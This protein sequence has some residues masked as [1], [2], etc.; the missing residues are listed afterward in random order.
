VDWQTIAAVASAVVALLA[1]GI[2][3]WQANYAGR[4]AR[5]AKR[6]AD[7]AEASTQA[8]Q[9][10]AEAAEESLRLARQQWEQQQRDRDE[11][12]TAAAKQVNATIWRNGG[13]YSV[14]INNFN[15]GSITDV[16][17]KNITV[18][19]HPDV[20]WSCPKSP[21]GDG[22]VLVRP[23]ETANIRVFFFRADG[24]PSRLPSGDPADYA[25]T[26]AFTD[27]I[28]TRWER[29][30]NSEPRRIMDPSEQR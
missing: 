28:G 1:M 27:P 13:M 29:T 17:L 14:Q 24:T 23:H 18:R 2:A 6:Q 30:G 25:I 7:A 19:G 8:A 20:T 16:V 12:A 9:R 5:E 26:F 11:Q 22:K 21:G 15:T 3:I 4:Q 10:Q